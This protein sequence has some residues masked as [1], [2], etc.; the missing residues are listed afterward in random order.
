MLSFGDYQLDPAQGLKLGAQDIKITPK[1]L[2]VLCLLVRESG[3]VVTKEEIF[4]LVWP[5]TIVS[6]A[7]LTSCI[8][9]LRGALRDQVKHPQYI[10]TLHRRG[11]RFIAPTSGSLALK[12]VA[13]LAIPPIRKDL[14]FVGREHILRR[15]S[16]AWKAATEGSRQTVFITGEAGS[17]K[18]TVVSNF[19]SSIAEPEHF[20]ATWAQCV[21]HIGLGEPYEPL[22]EA[23]TRL[24]QQLGGDHLVSILEQQAPTWLAQIPSLVPPRRFA[25]LQ[26][27]TA[28]T[29]RERMLRE[30]TGAMETIGSDVPLILWLEDLHWSDVSTLDWIAG[31]A[32]RPESARILLIG[33]YRSTEVAGSHHRLAAMTAE[34]GL[35]GLSEELVLDGLDHGE[36]D[37]YLRLRFPFDESHAKAF[38]N[39]RTLIQKHTAGNPLFIMHVCNDLVERSRIIERVGGWTLPSAITSAD[40]GIPD[41]LRRAIHNQIDGLTASERAVLKVASV[42][43]TTFDL[44][45]V[46]GVMNLQLSGVEA[47]AD[48][49][50]RRKRFIARC[51]APTYSGDR[52]D[53]G[54][55]FLHGLYRDAFYQLIPPERLREL[56]RRAGTCKE[57]TDQDGGHQIAAELAHHFELGLDTNRALFHLQ[58]A[59]QNARNRGAYTEAKM[60]LERALRLLSQ[61]PPSPETEELEAALLVQCGSISQATQGWAAKEAEVAFSRARGLF[62]GLEKDTRSFPA[63][64]GMWL[65]YWGRSFLEG[66]GELVDDLIDM[67]QKADDP[68]LVLQAHHAAWA[69]AFSRGDLQSTLRHTE[70]GLQLYSESRDSANLSSFGN[71]D[72]RVC[73][74]MFRARALALMGQTQEAV[75]SSQD[76]LAFAEHLAHPFSHAL[77]LVFASGLSQLLQDSRG[78][79]RHACEAADIARE[80]EFKLLLAWASAFEGWAQANLGESGPGLSKIKNSINSV[81]SVGCNQFQPHLL[82]LLAETLANQG[83]LTEAALTVDEALLLAKQTGERF[84]EPALLKIKDRLEYGNRA[85]QGN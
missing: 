27:I 34:L 81:R 61:I 59:A 1:S 23:I 25:E 6:D 54:F 71:H 69:T 49:L 63:V 78:T 13:Q 31:F 50:A 73:S 62:Q 4:R 42:A 75:R 83:H 82:G 44:P 76:S 5:D 9:E 46:S 80:Q 8:Q 41:S 79:L 45:V 67:A 16:R 56:H 60:H 72:A 68:G 10:E 30:L 28:G 24:C 21:Q 53:F 43:G 35:K 32:A 52:N 64:W 58:R 74:H 57:S 39:L 19:L 65:Y 40:L 14:P 22:L 29:T 20:R 77:A 17:G 7:A 66:A 15:L 26:R 12:S 47:I 36:V 11:Y 38:T 33:S 84:Y 51:E 85:R 37:H 55:H 3:R 2:A 70:A 48:S 18:T